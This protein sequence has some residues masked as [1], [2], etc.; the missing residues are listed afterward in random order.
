MEKFMSKVLISVNFSGRYNNDEQKN[1]AHEFINLFPDDDGNWHFYV[2]PYGIINNKFDETDYLLIVQH[3]D[4]KYSLLAIATNLK[5]TGVHQKNAT[6]KIKKENEENGRLTYCGIELKDWF[7]NQ[8]N[9]LYV[10]FNQSMQKKSRVY[11]PNKEITIEF[12]KNESNSLNTIFVPKK[13]YKFKDSKNDNDTADKEDSKERQQITGQSLIGYFDG[14]YFETKI[15]DQIKKLIEDKLLEDKT[16]ADFKIDKELSSY[17]KSLLDII[18]RPSDELAFSHWLNYYLQGDD[19]FDYFLKECF[20]IDSTKATARTSKLEQSTANRNRIDLWLEFDETKNGKNGTIILIENKVQSQIHTSKNKNK[21]IVSQL[22]DYLEKGN[23]KAKE[24]N[25]ILKTYLICPEYWKSYYYIE[26]PS[27]NKLWSEGKNG[28]YWTE[29]SYKKIK[30][31]LEKFKGTKS[32]NSDRY[33]YIDEL[34]KALEKHCKIIPFSTKDV[35][36]DRA[37]QRKKDIES[38]KDQRI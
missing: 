11:F 32:C 19:F 8:K 17:K 22:D 18:G 10:S 5:S 7:S 34:I 36:L 28:E 1:I 3:I 33:P 24:S 13:Y 27:G 37:S 31:C 9:T 26:N 29:V 12:E 6:I 2:P 35:I 14:S 20:S 4:K 16:N 15:E 38:K 25:K 21:E 23:E 30:E